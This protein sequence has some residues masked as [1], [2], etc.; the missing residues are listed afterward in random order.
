VRGSTFSSA[1]LLQLETKGAY[2]GRLFKCHKRLNT[3]YVNIIQ[4]WDT[5]FV[6]DV[7]QSD[8]ERLL[9]KIRE[10]L[11]RERRE[12]VSAITR[13][14]GIGLMF[15]SIFVFTVLMMLNK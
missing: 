8:E 9:D 13:N 6:A 4:F 1:A 12:T 7:V 5:M 15:M 3:Y 14:L 10:E 2:P 11:Q